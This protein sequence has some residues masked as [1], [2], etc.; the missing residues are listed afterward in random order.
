[1]KLKA[2]AKSKR[3]AIVCINDIQNSGDIQLVKEIKDLLSME[4]LGVM[5]N[6]IRLSSLENIQKNVD[7]AFSGSILLLDNQRNKKIVDFFC[8][9]IWRNI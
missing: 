5:R 3:G 8:Q 2:L 6:A 7:F 4:S 1:M 9:N